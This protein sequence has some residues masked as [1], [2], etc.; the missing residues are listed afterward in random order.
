MCE[1]HFLGNTN[2]LATPR[3]EIGR[4]SGCVNPMLNRSVSRTSTPKYG[5]VGAVS[6]LKELDMEQL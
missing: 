5:T 1:R 6:K 4:D 3:Y 2:N